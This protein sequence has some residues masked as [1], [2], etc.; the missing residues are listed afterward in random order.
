LKKETMARHQEG[1]HGPPPASHSWS[2]SLGLKGVKQEIRNSV[3]Q[4]TPSEE[5][6]QKQNK[7]EK[8]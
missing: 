2:G 3:K 7:A 8:L 6:D 1:N 4:V 5:A